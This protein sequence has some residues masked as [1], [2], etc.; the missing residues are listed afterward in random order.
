M[1]KKLVLA[2]ALLAIPGYYMFTQAAVAAN[3]WYSITVANN[4]GDGTAVAYNVNG[5][6]GML[7]DGFSWNYSGPKFHFRLVFDTGQGGHPMF[8]VP[9]GHTA[10]FSIDQNYGGVRV[11]F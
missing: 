5:I 9:A 7:A 1:F 2:L 11:D 4:C 10:S 3:N 6:P 8:W